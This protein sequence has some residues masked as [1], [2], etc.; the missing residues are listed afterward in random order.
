VQVTSTIRGLPTEVPLG[1]EH[2]LDHESVVNCDNLAMVPK[3]ALARH[4]GTLGPVELARL[5]DALRLA[6]ELDSPPRQRRICMGAQDP[7]QVVTP[8]DR[9][10]GPPTPG[11]DRQQ[12][13][14][15]QGMWAGFVRTDAGMVSGWHHHGDYES[16]IYVLTGALRM[17][18]GP[19]GQDV[20]EA[21][22][23]DFV[24]VPRG[25]VHREGNPAAQPADIVVV[26]AG[27]GES[28][29]NV[30]GPD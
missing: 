19:G 24:R 4:R 20:V 17:E 10:Q 3:A 2:G 1:R 29:F 5:R 23:G 14:A 18:S 7:I 25:V 16:V 30:A 6:L 12:A 26:R 13:F 28:T 22:A 21:H 11:M 9:T 15:S 8:A 27:R